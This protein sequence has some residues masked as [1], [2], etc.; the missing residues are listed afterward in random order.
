MTKKEFRQIV[1]KLDI[2]K[3]S[4]MNQGIAFNFT[5]L[6]KKGDYNVIGVGEWE[7]MSYLALCQLFE[8]YEVAKANGTDAEHFAESVK[9]QLIHFIDVKDKGEVKDDI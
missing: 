4:L 9:R 3:I 8:M 2:N 7:D 1:K 6:E 5:T